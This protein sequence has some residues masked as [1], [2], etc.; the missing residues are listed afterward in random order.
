MV[1]VYH[2]PD[3]LDYLIKTDTLR[4]LKKVAEVDTED[5]N[6]AYYLTN[7]IDDNWT[8]NPSLKVKGDSYRSTSVGDVLFK[9][10][11]YYTVEV[12]GFKEIR[13]VVIKNVVIEE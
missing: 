3:F 7:N 6:T 5:L 8:Q 2:N 10:G 12:L 4:L 11:K 13:E 1:I 9:D